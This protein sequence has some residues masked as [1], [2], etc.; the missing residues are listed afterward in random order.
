MRAA[1][2][3]TRF[4][5][6]DG[7]RVELSKGDHGP[8]NESETWIVDPAAAAVANPRALLLAL[9]LLWLQFPPPSAG[10][11]PV[12]MCIRAYPSLRG[13]LNT[14][15]LCAQ[16][17]TATPF[18]LYGPAIFCATACSIRLLVSQD[19]REQLFVIAATYKW[20]SPS[21]SKRALPPQLESCG[22]IP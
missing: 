17:F 2:T 21:P 14:T 5:G 3:K 11:A 4:L 12:P 7:P 18:F 10:P 15:G 20:Y 9:L 19:E 6:L 13:S 16:V 8:A 22:C 1:K